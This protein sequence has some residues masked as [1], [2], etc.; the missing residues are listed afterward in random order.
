MHASHTD[1]LEKRAF[2]RAPYMLSIA[3]TMVLSVY[4]EVRIGNSAHANPQGSSKSSGGIV[5]SR[6]EDHPGDQRGHLALE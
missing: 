4:W 3:G 2:D 6:G 5:A 1:A